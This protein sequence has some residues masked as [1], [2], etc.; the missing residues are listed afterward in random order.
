MGTDTCTQ[1]LNPYIRQSLNNCEDQEHIH[2][3]REGLN[4][5]GRLGVQMMSLALQGILKRKNAH[6]VNVNPWI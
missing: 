2:R 5:I 6:F 1:P 4:N 3:Y